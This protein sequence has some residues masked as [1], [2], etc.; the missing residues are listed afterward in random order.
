MYIYTRRT[1]SL[2]R[3]KKN[4]HKEC[5]LNQNASQSEF[6]LKEIK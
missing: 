4:W 6:C 5:D 3:Q 1:N 2:W